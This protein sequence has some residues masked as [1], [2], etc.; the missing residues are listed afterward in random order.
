MAKS[1]MRPI[2]D[3]IP[4]VEANAIVN[5]PKPAPPAVKIN[6]LTVPSGTYVNE[7]MMQRLNEKS[8]TFPRRSL[9]EHNAEPPPAVSAHE[10]QAEVEP[11]L[12]ARSPEEER[13]LAE[14]DGLT[15]D[16]LRDRA[17]ACGL[18]QRP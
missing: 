5:A 1:E 16:Q 3:T 15:D 6:I 13:L 17:I 11:P 12:E 7:A 18:D 4:L 8:D 14:L 10:P 9:I 2:K